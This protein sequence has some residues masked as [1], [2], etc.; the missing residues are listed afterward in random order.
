MSLCRK[1][2]A[3][4][5]VGDDDRRPGVVDLPVGR[6]QRVH[7]VA[8]EVADCPD[9]GRVVESG[10]EVADRAGIVAVCG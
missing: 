3:L 9:Q 1:A 4:Y 2:I 7:V 8:A 5:R 6:P 10:D